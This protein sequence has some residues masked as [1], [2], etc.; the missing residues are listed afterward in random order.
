MNRRLIFTVDLDR[1]VNLSIEG[2]VEAGSIDRGGCV[3]L[4]TA[5]TLL[6]KNIPGMTPICSWTFW[7]ISG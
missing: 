1:D 6:A 7:T 3:N 2:R 4:L 5:S